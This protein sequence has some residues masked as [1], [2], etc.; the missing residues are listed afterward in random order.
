MTSPQSLHLTPADAAALIQ[1]QILEAQSALDGS[2]LE[3]ALDSVIS[4]LGLALQL[5]PAASERVLSE[6]VAVAREL[7]RR[8][9]AGALAAL[10][11]ALVGLTQ[12]VKEAGA[13]PP[14]SVMHAWAE[15]AS[16]LGALIGQ[17][18]LALTLNSS[19]RA[20]MMGKARMRA[21][22]LDDATSDLFALGSWLDQ[23]GEESKAE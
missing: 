14:T 20:G 6:V 18:G 16:D 7:A 1:N 2:D 3:S 5:G 19:H 17:V 23:I 22:L 12:Q 11:P 13:L 4:A 10:G 9:D 21:A 15:L 8:D